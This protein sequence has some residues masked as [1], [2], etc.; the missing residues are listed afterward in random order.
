MYRTN[1]W[2]LF[3]LCRAKIVIT[4]VLAVGIAFQSQGQA[5]KGNYNF[6][7]F[8]SKPYYFGITLG[9]NSANYRVSHSQ[10]FIL[11]DS[12]ST[13]KS[14]S[15]SGFNLGIVT[16]LK[17]GQYFD[18]RFLPTLSFVERNIEYTGV[19][20]GSILNRRRIES[21]WVE[22]PFHLRYK[23]APYRDMRLFVIAG[24]KYGF[25]VASDSRTRQSDELVKI[26]PNDFTVE[27]GAGIQ[28]FFPYFIFSPEFKVSQGL[29]NI[30]IFDSNLEESNVLEK[31][32]SRAFTISLHFEG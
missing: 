3:G 2:N 4:A 27:Y 16:N 23:S 24:V 7:D 30:H 18:L 21:V 29:N 5:A 9:F 25:D 19:S 1:V 17:I 26:A 6:L 14:L 15:G 20:N 11:H 32:I 22:M 28:F 13:A 12:I 8:Q 31:I 10:D